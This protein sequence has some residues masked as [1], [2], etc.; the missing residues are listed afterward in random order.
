MVPVLPAGTCGLCVCGAGSTHAAGKEVLSSLPCSNL[1]AVHA[2]GVGGGGGVP[3]GGA[4]GAVNATTAV[5]VAI[6]GTAAGLTPSNSASSDSS[7]SR[8]PAVASSVAVILLLVALA[9][10]FFIHRS[11]SSAKRHSILSTAAANPPPSSPPRRAMPWEDDAPVAALGHAPTSKASPVLDALRVNIDVNSGR[12]NT[13]RTASPDQF[14]TAAMLSP[15]YDSDVDHTEPNYRHSAIANALR[16]Q[17]QHDTLPLAASY[18]SSSPASQPLP[19]DALSPFADPSPTT[20]TSGEYAY[21]QPAFHFA[22]HLSDYEQQQQYIWAYHWHEWQV[23]QREWQ[24]QLRERLKEREEARKAAEAA[25]AAAGGRGMQAPP[26]RQPRVY[27]P[28]PLSRVY[29]IASSYRSRRSHGSNA[30]SGNENIQPGTPPD[31]TGA[32]GL[33]SAVPGFNDEASASSNLSRVSKSISI[34]TNQSGSLLFTSPEWAAPADITPVRNNS[35][36]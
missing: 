5:S 3:G 22:Q 17:Q 30:A 24:L 20:T 31:L 23:R 1:T 6:T 8:I 15:A 12:F 11:K 26:S 32:T 16:L 7:P 10:A 25:V 2:G 28:S 21:Y 4:A 14:A 27:K 36:T 19:H 29:S 33:A 35:S 9:V 13:R 34:M 18:P